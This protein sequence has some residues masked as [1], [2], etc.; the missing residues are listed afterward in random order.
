MLHFGEIIFK[1]EL[2]FYCGTTTGPGKFKTELGIDI[3]EV[4]DNLKPMVDFKQVH[5]EFF[6]SLPLKMDDTA[7]D[8]YFKQ[9]DGLL[10][11]H[12]VKYFFTLAFAI[13]I[14]N[15]RNF[16]L[17]KYGEIPPGPGTQ[18]GSRFLND[19]AG[20]MRCYI[21]SENPSPELYR[22]VY[23][24]LNLYGPLHFEIKLKPNITN[25]A[26]HFYYAMQLC[27][28]LS[29]VEQK[30][31]EKHFYINSFMAHSESV[32]LSAIY[33]DNPKI[34]QWGLEKIRISRALHDENI[35]RQF[36]RPKTL[37][38]KAKN[39]TELYDPTVDNTSPPLLKPYDND[40]LKRH[41]LGIDPLPKPTA[42]CHATN[43]GTYVLYHSK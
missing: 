18:D 9:F 4:S 6:E 16:L 22:I 2:K 25:G 31:M 30:A 12:D 24:S 19:A 33:D 42:L 1:C 15:G 27:L 41:H 20:A 10:Q 32:L 26:K 7:I 13:S 37:N 34:R 5:S 3:S 21:Q 39:Y 17:K 11:N 35:V 43:T 29:K 8:F 38:W 28:G 14:P 23:I 40:R 36:I